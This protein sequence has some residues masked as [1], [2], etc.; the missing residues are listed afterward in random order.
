MSSSRRL[1][2]CEGRQM[3]NYKDVEPAVCLPQSSPSEVKELKTGVC[4]RSCWYCR[5]YKV[6]E[7]QLTKS[8]QCNKKTFRFWVTKT[9]W[10]FKN[11]QTK[12]IHFITGSSNLWIFKPGSWGEWAKY[13]GSWFTLKGEEMLQKSCCRCLPISSHPSLPFYLFI[14][15]IDDNFRIIFYASL[16]I[17]RNA[18]TKAKGRKNDGWKDMRDSEGSCRKQHLG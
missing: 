15:F 10:A 3:F 14:S 5:D 2:P 9:R 17:H 13:S 12:N 1:K 18:E 8:V 11:K 7:N 16:S 4:V 6:K